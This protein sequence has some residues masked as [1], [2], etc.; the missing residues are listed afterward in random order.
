MSVPTELVRVPVLKENENEVSFIEEKKIDP[1]HG[2]DVKVTTKTSGIKSESVKRS[3]V[4][5][6]ETGED[7]LITEYKSS[8]TYTVTT[9]ATVK[10]VITNIA[11]ERET[12]Q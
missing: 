6:T 12:I 4:I 8:V 10:E 5:K 2:D 3:A 11:L 9:T 7:E 1:G